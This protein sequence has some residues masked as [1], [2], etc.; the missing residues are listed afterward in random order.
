[1]LIGLA[2]AAAGLVFLGILGAANYAGAQ[3]KAA[4]FS[5]TP[6]AAPPRPTITPSTTAPGLQAACPMPAV[7]PRGE[8]LWIVGAGTQAGYRA[9]ETFMDITLPHEAV[10]RTEQVAGSMRVRQA[11]ANQVVI[12]DGC[13]AIA[14]DTLT[15]IDTLPGRR[16]QDRDELYRDFLDT[17]AYPY[18][19]LSLN[20][21]TVPVF[22]S[23]PSHMTLAG[24]LTVAGSTRPVA[25]AVDAQTASGGVR[26][27]GS[28]AINTT[29]FGIRLP[30]EGDPIVV[31]PHVTLEFFLA[32]ERVDR[33][34]GA[35]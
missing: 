5:L 31:D 26:A 1:V 6:S 15:S 4:A 12:Q 2:V 24:E 34:A 28:M 22:A 10:A 17:G 9:H 27:V 8:D 29:D 33:P 21:A 20:H 13:F 23:K 32:L 14:L 35:D 30:G 25:I 11:S 7:T 16:A 3:R 19:V 18:A